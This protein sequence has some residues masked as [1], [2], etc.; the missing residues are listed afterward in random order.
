MTKEKYLTLVN[1]PFK[2]GIFLFTKLPA[3]FF[4]GIR[5]GQCD[6]KTC[7][8]TLPYSWRSQNPFKSIFFAAQCAAGEL[9]TGMLCMAHIQGDVPVSMLV[10]RQ[11]AEFYKK[12]SEKMVFTC[13]Q[14]EEVA[15]VIKKALE[16]G[17][18]QIL[19]MESIGTLPDGIVASKV[20][21]TWSFKA[22]S[23]K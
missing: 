2:M 12:A 22:K 17:E 6:E 19:R 5:V 9:S 4:M 8:A 20:W 16:T 3:S 23:K 13:N 11:E 15:T 21:I 14:G 7:T 18:S 1:S 10:T